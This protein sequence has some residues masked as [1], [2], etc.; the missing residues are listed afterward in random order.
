MQHLYELSHEL[1]SLRISVDDENLNTELIE[2]ELAQV[3]IEFDDKVE[4]IAKMML[5]LKANE[6]ILATEIERLETRKKVVKG[7]YDWFKTYLTIEMGTAKVD[8]VKRPLVT[9]SLRDNPKQTV[10]ILDAAIIPHEYCKHIPESYVPDKELILDHMKETGEV[11]KG[12]E[13][14]T[15]KKYVTIK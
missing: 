2:N 7:K 10:N 8:K 9:V 12:V 14:I 13:I 11:V 6:K 5:E 15:D 4:A 3:Q 1:N